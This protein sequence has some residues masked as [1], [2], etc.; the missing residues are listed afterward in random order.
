MAIR[1]YADTSVYGGVFDRE[2]QQPSRQF[3]SLVRAGRFELVASALVEDELAY[4]P[5][6]VRHWF[7]Q[8][9]DVTDRVVIST[10]AIRLRRAYLA[11]GIVTAKSLTDALHVAIA[12]VSGCS[13]IVSWNFKHIVHFEKVP[14]YNAANVLHRWPELEIRSPAE[15]IEDDQDE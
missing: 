13:L 2:F 3:F 11:A 7:D 4:A 14:L 1:V 10:D 6:D 5:K 15:V 8:M 9:Q 12:S